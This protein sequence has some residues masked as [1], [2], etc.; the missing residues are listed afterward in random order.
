MRLDLLIPTFKRL[1]LLERAVES[2]A[3]V[4]L[5]RSLQVGV[6]VINN[7]ECAELPGLEAAFNSVPFPTRVLH[8][9]QPGKSAALNAGISVSS[10]DYIGFIDDDE[11]L[12]PDWF[13]VVEDAL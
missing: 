2:L 5:P 9:P 8:E 10:A 12:A 7:D 4:E 6:I 3:R 13:R 11:E 1:H